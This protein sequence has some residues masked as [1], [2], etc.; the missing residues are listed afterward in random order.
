M[1]QPSTFFGKFPDLGQS[2]VPQL[3]D[4]EMVKVFELIAA[5]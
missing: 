5:A 2:E 4:A 3:L 1:D